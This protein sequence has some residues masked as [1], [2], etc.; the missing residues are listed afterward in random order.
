MVYKYKFS[1]YYNMIPS[2]YHGMAKVICLER[3]RTVSSPIFPTPRCLTLL[4]DWNALL[5]LSSI[6]SVKLE[7]PSPRPYFIR[8][9][10][11][12]MYEV[13]ARHM[14][15]LLLLDLC[16]LQVQWS[17]CNIFSTQDHAAAAIAKSG[18]PGN[19]CWCARLLQPAHCLL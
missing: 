13:C 12:L 5:F 6:S 7:F 15:S 18:V 1:Y 4:S 19:R 14:L 3:D 8:K 11:K 2:F 10:M 16:L 17:S 9:V